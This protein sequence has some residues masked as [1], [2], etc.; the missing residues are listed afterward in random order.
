MQFNILGDVMCAT[1]HNNTMVKEGQIV[2]GTRAIP[3]TVKKKVAE[4]T[5]ILIS[6]ILI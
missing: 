3:L 2:T 4:E 5:L 1:L 6:H